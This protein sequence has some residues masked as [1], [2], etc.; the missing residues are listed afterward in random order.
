MTQI[1]FNTMKK[2]KKANIERVVANTV[3]FTLLG[4]P[5]GY[6]FQREDVVK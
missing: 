3:A 1:N 5:M 4:I 2:Y 6:I